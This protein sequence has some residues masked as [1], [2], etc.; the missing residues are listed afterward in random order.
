MTD[1]FDLPEDTFSKQKASSTGR[2]V[3]ENVYDPDP[4]SHNGSYKSVFRF[5]PYI[6]DKTKS[7]YTKYTAKFWNPLTKESVIVDC[8][9]NT[10]QPSILWTIESVLRSLRKEEPDLVKDID[11]RF[12]RWYTHH[13][14]VYIKKDPQRPDLE[15]QLKIFKFRNQIDQLIDQMVNP[16]EVDGMSLSKKVNPYHLLE[17]KDFFCVVGKKTKEFRDWSKCKFMDEITPFVF[18]I[19]EDQVVVE[20]SE[21]SVKL[22]NEF[23]TKRT[24]KMDDYLHQ[25]WKEEDFSRVAEAILAAIPQKEIIN[26]VL[27]RSKDTKMNELLRER[28]SGNKSSRSSAPSSNPMNDSSEDLIFASEK[29]AAPSKNEESVFENTESSDDDEYDSLFKN[30]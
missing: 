21:K 3:D 14:V 2:K 10:G 24:P 29:T 26:M 9:S 15:G 23:L 20:N 13:S 1:F 5:V 18:K 25:D 12:S 30:L 19:G 7:K 22:V 11:S 6:F 28:L 8:P 17:G 16:E 4:N 27:E